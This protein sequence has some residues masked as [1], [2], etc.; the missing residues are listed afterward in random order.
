MSDMNTQG[1]GRYDNM[2]YSINDS[3]H[4]HPLPSDALYF[5]VRNKLIRRLGFD[6]VYRYSLYTSDKMMEG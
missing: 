4:Y 1:H 2:Y 5:T 6:F 3:R